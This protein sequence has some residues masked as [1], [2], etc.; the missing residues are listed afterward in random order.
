MISFTVRGSHRQSEAFLKKL[1]KIDIPS[2]LKKNGQA[3]VDAL[4]RATPIDS[5]LASQSWA[6]EVTSSRGVHQITWTNSDVESG[7]PVAIMLQ[8]GYGT[9]TGGYVQG[10]DYINPAIRPIFDRIAEDVWKAVTSL[11][12]QSKN[13]LSE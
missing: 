11:W 7:F 1:Q 5:S 4:A 8:Y 12:L 2:I 9:G 3:G 10:V 6:Y 13:A